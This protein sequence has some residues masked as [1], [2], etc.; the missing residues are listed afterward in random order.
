MKIQNNKHV[1]FK[2]R[3]VIVAE[4]LFEASNYRDK[5]K[6]AL[7]LVEANNYYSDIEPVSRKMLVTTDKDTDDFFIEM[8]KTDK[9]DAVKKFL[10]GA[11]E[12]GKNQI[13]Q[14]KT[15]LPLDVNY[16]LNSEKISPHLLTDYFSLVDK[17]YKPDYLEPS[18]NVF[19][20]VEDC[21]TYSAKLQEIEDS[22]VS[23]REYLIARKNL[24]DTH[25]PSA[26]TFDNQ[27]AHSMIQHIKA[28]LEYP[29]V[30]N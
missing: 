18:K 23:N 19:F 7:S 17:K 28:V 11:V 21:D 22:D 9:A 24:I 29:Q 8:R 5:I 25:L 3:Y 30:T 27:N 12:F 14:I 4:N 15:A 2:Q 20:A 26:K 1:S 10:I 13:E 6:L 16:R